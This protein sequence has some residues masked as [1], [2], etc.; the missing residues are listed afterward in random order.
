MSVHLEKQVKLKNKAYIKA[1][2]FDEASIVILAEYSNYSN[3]FSAE[4]IAEL[5]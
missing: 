4:I 1:L 2:I 5:L 3:V